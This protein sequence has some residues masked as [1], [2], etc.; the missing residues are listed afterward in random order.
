MEMKQD[1]LSPALCLSSLDKMDIFYAFLSYSTHVAESG[2]GNRAYHMP[3][4]QKSPIL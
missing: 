2:L 1:C 3:Y 4:M